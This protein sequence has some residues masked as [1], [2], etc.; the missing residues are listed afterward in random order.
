MPAYC[1]TFECPDHQA[2]KSAQHSADQCSHDAAIDAT[3]VNPQFAAER[4][5]VDAANWVPF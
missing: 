4:S 5:A 2:H 1:T 3:L